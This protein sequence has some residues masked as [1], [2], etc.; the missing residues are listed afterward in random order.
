M[1]DFGMPT[2]VE[3][4]DLE[5]SAIL[6]RRLG[7]RFIELNM[8]FPQYQAEALD[9][10]RLR[11]IKERHGIYYTIHIDESTDPCSVN[12]GIAE[13]YTETMLK[14]V[15]IA[16][17][18]E[19]PTL[20]MHLLRGIYATLPDR[21]VYVYGENRDFYLERLRAFRDA[22]T[23]AI[24]ESGVKICIENT[25][26]YDLPFLREGL[27]T[28][29]E[30]PAFALTLDVGHDHAIGGVDLP[31]IMERKDRLRHMHLHD[32]VGA[33][34]HLALGDGEL[35][36]EGYLALAEE[37]GCRVVLETK[38]VDAL[39]AS[40]LWVAHYLN[41]RS[42]PEELWD[43]YDRDRRPM[44]RLHKRGEMLEEGDFHLVVHV[45][46][47]NSRGE[48]LLTKR[49]PE[50]GCGGMWESPGGS[51][52][53]GED[54]L[55][56]ALREIR[57]ETGFTLDPERGSVA[58]VFSADHFICDVWLFRQDF[59]LDKARLLP[60]E[61]TDIMYA[62]AETVR[63]MHDDGTMVPFEYLEEILAL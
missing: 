50:K 36:K 54:S 30:S 60:G 31:V 8:S 48:Y 40:A 37:C 62:D 29:L 9:V 2:L 28:L 32:A 46:M 53:A 7:L 38:T 55:T 19:I 27:D 5:Q 23:Q 12:S 17:A 58:R 33:R 15:A 63:R 59:E 4:G 24:G 61:T 39:T 22:M 20:N 41:R 52:Q 18:L 34:V 16:R 21:R 51:V 43:V 47:K 35:D 10:E 44:G 56:A 25:D 14:T 6:C 42:D 1:T 45:W 3:L 49:A 26:G 57:E 11:E 13:V